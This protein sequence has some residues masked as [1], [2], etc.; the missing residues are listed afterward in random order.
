MRKTGR[1]PSRPGLTLLEVM[2]ALVILGGALV[3]IGELIRTGSRSARD[4]RDA[5][6]AQV[7]ADSLM[8]EIAAGIVPAL[9]TDRQPDPYDPEFVYSVAVEQPNQDGL[10][11]ITVTVERADSLTSGQRTQSFRLVR[12]MLDPNVDLAPPPTDEVAQ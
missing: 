2:L 5:T 9:T 7:V 10:L 11:L 6:N 8:S 3:A 12:W 1:L 4:A